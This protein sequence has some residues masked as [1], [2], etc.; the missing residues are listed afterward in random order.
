MLLGKN[1]LNG[2][3]MRAWLASGGGGTLLRKKKTEE[4]REGPSPLPSRPL[5]TPFHTARG[6]GGGVGPGRR[7]ICTLPGEGRTLGEKELLDGGAPGHRPGKH[8]DVRRR[9]AGLPGAWA[10]PNRYEGEG[11]KCI[12]GIGV[13]CKHGNAVRC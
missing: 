10:Q 12:G 2:I 13:L 3:A 8:P 1:H 4:E 5:C 6:E 7:A 9:E 11:G